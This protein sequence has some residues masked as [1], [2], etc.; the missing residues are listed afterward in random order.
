MSFSFRHS[1]SREW[2]P[3]SAGFQR[4]LA[5]LSAKKDSTLRARRGRL[6]FGQVSVETPVFMP[7]G[8]LGSVKSL[9]NDEVVQMGYDLILANTYH[10]KIRPGAEVLRRQGGLHRFMAWQ[11]AI[12]TD[13]GGFQV[14]SLAERR[15]IDEEGVSFASHIDGSPL[16]LTPESVVEMQDVIGSNIQMVLDECTPYPASPDEVRRSMERSMRWARRARTHFEQ[17][18]P[19]GGSAAQFGIV[20]GGMDP[21]L[22]QRSA[23]ELVSLGFEGLAVGGLSV[24]EGKMEMRSVLGALQGHLPENKPRYLMG[25]GSPDDLIDGVLQGVDMFDCV[26]PTRNAR[27]GSVFVR[28]A[29]SNGIGKLQIKNA[30][31]KFSDQPLDSEC[32]CFTCRTYSR[33]YLRHLFVSGELLALRL[34]TLHNL[35]FIADLMSEIREL[36]DKEDTPAE[37][38]NDIRSRFT[39]SLNILK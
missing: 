2:Q 16:R 38:F 36:L 34:L 8:T 35:Q 15:K 37:G 30:Q 6:D 21:L 5:S 7:V 4:E 32:S 22:R 29:A 26:M 19:K 3:P 20:Q 28:S 11:G 18:R 14:M 33:A 39:G 17:E 23:A 9:S 25:V 1:H 27:N 10:L 31:H 13:S 12:L 24:G